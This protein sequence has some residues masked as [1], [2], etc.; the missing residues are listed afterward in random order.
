MDEHQA[1]EQVAH[2]TDDVT[3][4]GHLVVV[5]D[6]LQVTAASPVTGGRGQRSHSARLAAEEVGTSQG[7]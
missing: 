4:V 1:L 3:L 2:E 6:A 5:E 7:S